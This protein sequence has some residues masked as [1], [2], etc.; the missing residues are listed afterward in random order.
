MKF[1][2]TLSSITAIV[3]KEYIAQK[4]KKIAEEKKQAKW[5][6]IIK[7]TTVNVHKHLQSYKSL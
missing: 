3:I 4:D 2:I 6:E 7:N 1:Y 5:K